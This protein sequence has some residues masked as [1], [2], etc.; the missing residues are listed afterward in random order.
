MLCEA[1]HAQHYRCGI[2]TVNCGSAAEMKA[3][4]IA[5]RPV[6]IIVHSKSKFN[7][8]QNKHTITLEGLHITCTFTVACGTITSSGNV[9]ED[10]AG[11]FRSVCQS[12][13]VE[14][15]KHCFGSA[16]TNII[17]LR[18]KPL[19]QNQRLLKIV[20]AWM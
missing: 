2:F 9:V 20:G 3:A 4:L 14:Q 17:E 12:C 15:S 11:S 19:S 18:V 7:R 13:L 6:R 1:K 5:E 10:L 8:A 16:F